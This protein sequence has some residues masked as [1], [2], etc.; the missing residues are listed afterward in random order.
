MSREQIDKVLHMIL[1]VVIVSYNVKFFLEQCLSSLKKAV[2]GISLPG[3]GAEVFIVDNASTDGTADF[4]VSLYPDFHFIRNKE[5]SG[6]AKANNQAL[7]QCAGQYVLF[8]NPDTIIAEDCLNICL[9][10]FLNNTDAGALGVRLIDGAGRYLK[11]S[12]RG[13]PDPSASFFK[14]SGLARLFPRSKIFSAY[15]LGHLGEESTN[16]VDILSGAFMMVKK[17]V[18]DQIGGFDER[19]F[20]YAEDIDLSYR[21]CKAGFRNYYLPETTII[22]FK[23][24][25]TLRDF[26]YVKMFYSA[27]Q[28]F[29]KKHF[30]NW[31][32]S[33]L[34]ITLGIGMRF[35]QALAFILLSFKKSDRNLKSRL[36]V[37]IQEETANKK[38]IEKKLNVSNIPV[39]ENANKG[40]A[41]LFC[42]STQM[43]W[44]K[45]ITE[46]TNDPV[47]HIYYFHGEG[48]H[49]AVSSYSSREQGN[50]IEL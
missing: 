49:S 35:R 31:G 46:I 33:I 37:F 40:V 29:I 21:I 47:R 15:Y 8:L 1:S 11:E 39:S 7:S 17:T 27:M 12:K 4:L 10:F 36:P 48:T 5:N 24:E 3:G 13:F 34:I 2:D 19:F 32:S 6:F 23:G 14:L 41:I 43:S 44:K 16:A 50:V 30:K 38:K 45:I 28:L 42:E 9:S 25:S 18:L 26:R 20:M 22:H